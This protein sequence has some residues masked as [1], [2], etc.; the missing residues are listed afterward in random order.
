MSTVLVASKGNTPVFENVNVSHPYSAS[1]AVPPS[2]DGIAVALCHCN[3]RT[4]RQ[5]HIRTPLGRLEVIY[6]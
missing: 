6:C 3:R 2:S 1:P 4:A 5:A